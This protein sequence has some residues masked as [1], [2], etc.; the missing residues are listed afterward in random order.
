MHRITRK[1]RVALLG[2]CLIAGLGSIQ[3]FAADPAELPA[4]KPEPKVALARFTTGVENREPIDSVSFLE[5]SAE[6]I[7]FFTD[8]RNMGGDTV[9]HR[10]Q[11]GGEVVAEVPFEVR[12]DRYRVWSSKQLRP[13]WIG[14]WRVS[15]VNSA[16]EV[17][18]SEAFTLQTV[19]R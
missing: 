18:A 13:D 11:H 3:A 2:L 6:R 5:S 10:W 7:Y 1:H 15:V 8:L 12:S 16:G 19:Q 14:E 17:L 4:A 9:T